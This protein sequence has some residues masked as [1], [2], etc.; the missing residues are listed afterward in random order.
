MTTLVLRNL[1]SR[2]L[3]H[4]LTI[5]GVAVSMTLLLSIAAL[6]DGYRRG[7]HRELDRSGVQLMLV[8]LGCP[9]DA[10]ARVLKNNTLETSLPSEVLIAARAD[11]NVAVAAPLLMAAL[12][13]QGDQRTDMWVGLDDAALR[14]KPWWK[15]QSG[16]A[17]LTNEHEV[18]VG[19]DA[20]A[21]EMRGVGDKF[22]SPETQREFRVAGVL[23]RSGTSD[24]SVFFVPLATAQ[25]MFKQPDRLTAIAIRLHDPAK[26]RETGERL[27]KIPGAQ[28]VTMTEMMGTFLNLLGAMRTL[29]VA[30]AAIAI[31]VS[32]LSV[33]N[34]LLAGVLERT[35]E[36]TVLRAIGASRWQIVSLL[37]GE[38]L[39]LTVAGALVG[40][41][42][43]FAGGPI[44]EAAAKRF[45][46]FA[47][48]K[49][50]LSF[51]FETVVWNF[52]IAALVGIA[53]AV[54]PAWRASRAQ[55]ASATKAL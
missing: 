34:T 25:A 50:A 21:L 33:F 4:A 29:V 8:P 46:P 35:N 5:V 49:T 32:A 27:Q 19:A 20:A 1:T 26:L 22:F 55:P 52:A 7:L 40:L 42:L 15:A 24:D 39:L 2:P 16:R 48:E 17:Q 53:A 54:Y 37:I 6:G 45:I 36:L 30:L 23:E 38:A 43:A 31:S 44:I 41:A 12:P 51:T 13:R 18:I 28:V 9:Y 14:L 47:H 3:R 11:T 10:A